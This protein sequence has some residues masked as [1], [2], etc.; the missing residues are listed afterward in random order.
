MSG[1]FSESDW[2]AFRKYR[3]EMLEALAHRINAEAREILADEE[4]SE[5]DRYYRLFDHLRASDERVARCFD[6]W[7]RSTLPITAC[8]L[9][10]EDLVS[11]ELWNQ[12]NPDTRERLKTLLEIMDA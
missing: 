12:L 9:L 5:L 11:E 8:A 10:R 2:K 1:P 7:R 4:T 3:N 6:D